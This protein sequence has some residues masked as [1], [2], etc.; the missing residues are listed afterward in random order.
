MGAWIYVPK[1][2]GSMG[3][4]GAYVNY[5][6]DADCTTLNTVNGTWGVGIGPGN[7][8]FDAWQYAHLDF[9]APLPGTKAGAFGVSVGSNQAGGM[10]QAYFDSLYFT[11]APGHF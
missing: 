9:I 2:V 4:E 8:V 11:P 6:T 5:F 3:F 7:T 1:A 10:G